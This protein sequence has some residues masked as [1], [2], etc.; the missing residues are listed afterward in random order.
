MDRDIESVLRLMQFSGCE[1]QNPVLESEMNHDPFSDLNRP[2][3][4][5]QVLDGERVLRAA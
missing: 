4:V 3:H 5:R 1:R 2:R